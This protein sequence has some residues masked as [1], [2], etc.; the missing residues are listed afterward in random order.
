MITCDKQTY[1]AE[2][3]AHPPHAP[4]LNK[5]IE[6]YDEMAIVVGKDMATGGFSKQWSEP[7]PLVENETPQNDIQ[8]P[9]FEGDSNTLPKDAHEASNGTSS[10]GRSHRK[11]TYAA[12]NE[13]SPFINIA[14]KST[15]LHSPP[16]PS[17]HL[18]HFLPQ[19]PSSLPQPPNT[20]SPFHSKAT[21]PFSSSPSLAPSP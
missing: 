14:I 4:Y 20:N 5:K 8:N 17:L 16:K 19:S 10:K 21:N 6:Q 7:S 15:Q 1:D 13:D 2:V 18:R 9:E 11:R 3:L 12:M